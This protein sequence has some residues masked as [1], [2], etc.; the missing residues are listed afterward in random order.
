MPHTRLPHIAWEVGCKPQKNHKSK[1]L[2]SSL[3]E[4]IKKWFSKWNVGAHVDMHVEAGTEHEH[5]LNF[6][7]QLLEALHN[8]WKNAMHKSKFEYYC[9]HINA[10]YWE[11]YKIGETQIHIRTPMSY[12]ARR[13]ITLMRTR[14]HMLKSEIGGWLNI[15]ANM[16]RCT[17][18]NLN[19]LEN[20]AHV[21]LECLAYPHIQVDFP[22][23]I[24]GCTTF[25]EL[26]SRTHPSLV[27]LSIYL[28]KVLEHHTTLTN[29]ITTES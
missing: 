5:E 8:K 10:R 15:D 20:E 18:C 3:V 4:D 21:T 7:L 26:L 2:T 16:R 1:F 11:E 22:Q 19:S 9:K 25:E 24:Q 6:E 12:R 27:A 14:S 17:Q 13:A 28:A 23:L 29:K